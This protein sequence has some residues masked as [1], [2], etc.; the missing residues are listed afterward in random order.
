[1]AIHDLALRL[2][3]RPSS[4]PLLHRPQ[5]SQLHQRFPLADATNGNQSGKLGFAGTGL[6]VFPTVDGQPRYP[7]QFA[8]VR[9]RQPE[10]LS[11]SLDRAGRKAN[12]FQLVFGGLG[13]ALLLLDFLLDVL[14]FPFLLTQ[15]PF[16]L[17]DVT[18]VLDGSLFGSCRPGP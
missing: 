16:Q 9:S 11:L 10:S 2:S 1:M 3:P 13:L 8:V 6:L 12:A 7:N 17:G 14:D 4:W 5:F 15:Q 18:P